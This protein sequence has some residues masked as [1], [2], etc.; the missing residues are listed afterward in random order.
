MPKI[1]LIEDDKTL[2]R[3]IKQELEKQ[4]YST[5]VVDDFHQ[6]ESR[7]PTLKADLVLLDLSLPYMR[8]PLSS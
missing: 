5:L 3:L 8:C 1:L 4:G 6:L 2:R 7:L